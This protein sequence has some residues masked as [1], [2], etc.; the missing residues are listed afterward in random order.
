MS[1]LGD[2]GG[3]GSRESDSLPAGWATVR[4]SEICTPVSKLGREGDHRERF[5]YVDIS[6]VDG[7]S[8]RIH[9]A[10][11]VDSR[12]APSRARQVLQRGDTIYSTVRPY[13][14]KIA[15]VPPELDGHIASTGFAVIRPSPSVVPQY[16]F[17][18]TL[19]DGFS[20]Q[21]LP[22][23]RGVS[24]PAVREAEVFE[25]KIP[26]P[27][28][29][30]QHRIVEAL[31]TQISRLDAATRT[32]SHSRARSKSLRKSLTDRAL[33]GGFEAASE[34]DSPVTEQLQLIQAEVRGAPASKQRKKITA[35]SLTEYTKIPRHWAVCPLGT[36]VSLLDYGTSAK[37]HAEPD[38]GDIAVIRMGNIQ[39]GTLDMGSLKYLPGTHPDVSKY[40]LRDG[41]LLFNRTNSAELVGK[42]AV[43]RD[44]NGPA[45]YASYLIRCRLADGVEPDW[46]NLCINSAEGR[47]YIG[48][49]V[50]QQVGQ[51]NVN[52]AKLAS[53]PLPLPPH[54][55]QLRI[56]C[57]MEEASHSISRLI[58]TASEAHRGSHGLRRS[59]L[60]Y[61]FSGQL[62][63][64]DSADE[65]ASEL[66]ARIRA[67]R[68]TAVKGKPKAQ[69]KRGRR[70]TT[71]APDTG[72]PPPPPAVP[73]PRPAT[74]VQQ[75]FED[76]AP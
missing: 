75:S 41:D 74:A 40:A 24:Y 49:V 61:A 1:D 31:E 65:P 5:R 72:P 73:T 27:P 76:L 16:I 13:L 10:E 33:N 34:H 57:T 30:E 55:E 39:D 56:L 52:G 37:A 64:Q 3:N 46:V 42:S 4:L 15:L 14:R 51:A 45:V 21:L 7:Q 36:L 53:F 44:H 19:A 32:L 6:S 22:Q 47:R 25:T 62:V 28:V 63:P 43:Y 59:L 50:S 11:W 29:A 8:Q 18:A 69:S 68:D 38:P 58:Q 71:A 35:S 48:S 2:G 54:G 12:T 23:Q 20:R 60:R 67:E 17:Y 26:L 70:T 9:S 66:L